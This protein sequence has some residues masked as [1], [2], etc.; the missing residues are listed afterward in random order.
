M[1]DKPIAY[2]SPSMKPNPTTPDIDGMWINREAPYR[3][4]RVWQTDSER[5]GLAEEP[6]H[7]RGYTAFMA[8]RSFEFRP[9]KKRA[10]KKEDLGSR[11]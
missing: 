1:A 11:I 6:A 3:V 7:I 10:G 8:H 2:Y 9:E 5:P 4:V